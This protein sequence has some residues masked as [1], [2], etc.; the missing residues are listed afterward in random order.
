MREKRGHKTSTYLIIR[1]KYSSKHFCPEKRSRV[2]FEIAVEAT[3]L[4]AVARKQPREI[5][6]ELATAMFIGNLPRCSRVTARGHADRHDGANRCVSPTLHVNTP[7]QDMKYRSD[8][9][10]TWL[11]LFLFS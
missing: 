11:R 10:V 9:V 6:V 3:V 1:C 5:L 4:T 8:E 2:T 7:K